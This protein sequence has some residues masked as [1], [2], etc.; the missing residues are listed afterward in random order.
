VDGGEGMCW[1]IERGG[2]SCGAA[3]LP[4][5]SPSTQE[6]NVYVTNY[7]FIHRSAKSRISPRMWSKDS[8]G[9]G[10]ASRTVST[11]PWKTW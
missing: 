6:T 10:I 4:P 7:I 1:L 5:P 9:S 8:I 11:T 2:I 3:L